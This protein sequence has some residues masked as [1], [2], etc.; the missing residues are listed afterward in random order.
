MYLGDTPRPPVWA[1]AP[2]TPGFSVA[3][4]EDG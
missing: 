4:R 2:F 1:A 3:L